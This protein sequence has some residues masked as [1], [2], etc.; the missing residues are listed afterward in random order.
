MAGID[1]GKVLDDHI[2]A[3]AATI[4]VYGALVGDDD[5][6]TA[7]KRSTDN[8]HA[9]TML[10]MAVCVGI[11]G[12]RSLQ[13]EAGGGV[14]LPEPLVAALRDGCSET[15]C[16]MLQDIFGK[17]GIL[18][19]AFSA[20]EGGKAA[21]IGDVEMSARLKSALDAVGLSARDTNGDDPDDVETPV[22]KISARLGMK[23]GI[24]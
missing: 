1:L 4:R 2:A 9:L 18:L 17:S 13:R 16:A 22:S 3:L 20:V 12:L 5:M 14:G 19:R 11:R 10:A 21:V 24:C 6:E 23:P 8:R 15:A 7:C